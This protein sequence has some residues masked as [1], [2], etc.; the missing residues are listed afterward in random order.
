MK[1][2]STSATTALSGLTMNLAAAAAAAASAGT[3]IGSMSS[4]STHGSVK[5]L[6]DKCGGT[7]ATLAALISHKK[8]CKGTISRKRLAMGR[9]I[10]QQQQLKAKSKECLDDEH[11]KNLGNESANYKFLNDPSNPMNNNNP[12]MNPFAHQMAAAAA[13]A[14]A[15]SNNN[16]QQQWPGGD[17]FFGSSPFGNGSMNPAELGA[18]LETISPMLLNNQLTNSVENDTT[19]EEQQQQQQQQQAVLFTQQMVLFHMLQ[20]LQGTSQIPPLPLLAAA[21]AAAAAAN[22]QQQQQQQQTNLPP[23]SPQQYHQHQENH[24]S[25]SS[26]SNNADPC[27]ENGSSEPNEKANDLD[28]DRLNHYGTFDR[29]DRKDDCDQM[30]RSPSNLSS[31]SGTPPSSTPS[32]NTRKLLSSLM[33]LKD[34]N[35]DAPL[36][37]MMS[38]P[39]SSEDGAVGTSGTSSFSEP[40]TLELLQKHTEQ[41]LQNTM[42][43]GSFLLNGSTDNGDLLCFRKGKD[44]KEDPASRHRCRYCGKVFGSDSALQI[45][46]RSHTGERPFKC[47]VCGNRFT[48][49]GNLKVHFQRHKA[50]YPH[51]KMNPHPVP[52]HLDKFHPPLEPP[53]N[54]QSPPPAPPGFFSSSGSSTNNMN[55]NGG[56]NNNNNFSN[57]F[58]IPAIF[59]STLIP[60]G[61]ESDQN[62]KVN[63]DTSKTNANDDV[64]K[65]TTKSLFDFSELYLN[66]LEHNNKLREDSGRHMGLRMS[67]SDANPSDSSQSE[68]DDMKPINNGQDSD[69]SDTDLDIDSGAI[70]RHKTENGNIKR[71]NENDKDDDNDNDD[72][73][74]DEDAGVD[75][76][77]DDEMYQSKKE[78]LTNN[79]GNHDRKKEAKNLD[80]ESNSQMEMDV[81]MNGLSEVDDEQMDDE[82]EDDDNTQYGMKFLMIIFFTFNNIPIY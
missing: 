16:G 62:G 36:P 67:E 79:N 38:P 15:T 57:N 32:S 82:D 19:I 7:Y 17:G 77:Q 37:P 49:K 63:D 21:A 27:N 45:H 70:N 3:G 33:D 26:S 9:H 78:R 68:C 18:F 69:E 50:K 5:N 8:S 39:K 58:H 28:T 74:D 59:S 12:L 53:S 1:S 40:N 4:A 25:P 72:D 22:Q 34:T 10:Q 73:D 14:A 20:Q 29:S 23:S 75:Q 56:A 31:R 41:A 76:T 61:T 66:N 55:G 47:N 2:N 44:G 30:K 46:I 71:K 11:N 42:S 13:A 6:C 51:V 35:P 48:T 43:G 52:E 65:K 54:S 64:G 81:E 80:D 24:L 60:F